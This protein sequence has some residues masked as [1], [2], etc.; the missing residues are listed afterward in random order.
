[1]SVPWSGWDWHNAPY[2]PRRGESAQ[3]RARD[4][5]GI[6]LLWIVIVKFVNL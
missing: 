2:S 1:M 4:R 5:G 6:G 3:Q